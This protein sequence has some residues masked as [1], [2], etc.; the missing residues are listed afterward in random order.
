MEQEFN[1]EVTEFDNLR[2]EYLHQESEGID[3]M[4]ML[5]AQLASEYQAYRTEAPTEAD[6]YL[7][8]GRALIDQL[9]AWAASPQ[10]DADSAFRIEAARLTLAEARRQ[11]FEL[12]ED[13]R[14]WVY[15]AGDD[16]VCLHFGS[17]TDSVRLVY[18]R[19]GFDECAREAVKRL[20]QQRHKRQREVFDTLRLMQ[21]TL[22]E[23]RSNDTPLNPR[24]IERA[25]VSYTIGYQSDYLGN[26]IRRISGRQNKRR[27]NS[28]EA[29]GIPPSM[30]MC[31]KSFVEALAQTA[32]PLIMTGTGKTPLFRFV[33]SIV[34]EGRIS[35]SWDSY[36]SKT[37]LYGRTFDV[38]DATSLEALRAWWATSSMQEMKRLKEIEQNYSKIYNNL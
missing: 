23:S 28:A 13:D 27:N 38:T 17:D 31:Y 34:E 11:G 10:H 20:Q 12:K 22:L 18:M 33:I 25:F 8:E 9:R 30:D 16:R 24:R 4:A 14:A 19:D 32:A 3:F 21:Q 37:Y 29:A 2:N 5:E 7:A 26:L 6:A 35:V 15:L 1:V 36:N